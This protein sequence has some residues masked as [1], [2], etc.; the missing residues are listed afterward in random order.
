MADKI[1]SDLF[2]DKPKAKDSP[3]PS[4]KAP[5]PIGVRLSWDELDLL[6][7]VADKLGVNKNQVLKAGVLYYLEGVNSDEIKPKVKKENKL[8]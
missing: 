1:N 2:G 5:N 3:R 6:N 4:K 8:V 7:R